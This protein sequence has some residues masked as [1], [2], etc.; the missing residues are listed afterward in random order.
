[1]AARRDPPLI[2]PA[3]SADIFA[4]DFDVHDFNDWFRLICWADEIAG[5]GDGERAAKR[6]AAK[7][8]IPRSSQTGLIRVLRY[9]VAHH[10]INARP[11]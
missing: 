6:P 11:H 8:V 2:D 4:S 5:T 3:L 1:M 10:R 9:S 7:L